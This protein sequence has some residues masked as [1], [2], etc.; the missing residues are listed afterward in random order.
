MA[1]EEEDEVTIIVLCDWWEGLWEWALCRPKRRYANWRCISEALKNNTPPPSLKIPTNGLLSH[2]DFWFGLCEVGRMQKTLMKT[3][4]KGLQLSP[5]SW[6]YQVGHP[7]GQASR[8]PTGCSLTAP[9]GHYPTWHPAERGSKRQRQETLLIMIIT[10]KY[11]T[12]L[13][14]FTSLHFKQFWVSARRC[15]VLF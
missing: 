11:I 6:G 13:I 3:T 1:E 5:F 4:M 8:E 10:K 14:T 9:P 7:S 2:T 15:S 12:D